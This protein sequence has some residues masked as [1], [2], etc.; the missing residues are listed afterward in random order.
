[1][2]RPFLDATD[3][4]VEVD[5]SVARTAGAE[6]VTFAVDDG[7][8]AAYRAVVGR[9]FGGVCALIRDV[10]PVEGVLNTPL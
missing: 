1:M 4:G 10:V 9:V 3:Q 6:E 2:L 5:G 8:S 7:A